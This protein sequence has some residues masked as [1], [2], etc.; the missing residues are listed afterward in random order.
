MQPVPQAAA[1]PDSARF[2]EPPAR[3]APRHVS[4][5][6]VRREAQTHP[7]VWERTVNSLPWQH[8][9]VFRKAR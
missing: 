1:R 9:V 6:Q 5:A 3:S 2:T 8:R 7:L 4:E